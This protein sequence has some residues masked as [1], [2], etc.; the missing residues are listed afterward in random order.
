[1]DYIFQK[2]RFLVDRVI[3]GKIFNCKLI[4]RGN[5]WAMRTSSS[6]ARY[7]GVSQ[8]QRVVSGHL[9]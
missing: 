5:S 6:C 3:L 2:D 8:H 1:M 9:L 7:H 4:L